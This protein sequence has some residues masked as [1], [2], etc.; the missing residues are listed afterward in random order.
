MPSLQ[1][2]FLTL[3]FTL[4][5]TGAWMTVMRKTIWKLTRL[6]WYKLIC[7]LP[8]PVCGHMGVCVTHSVFFHSRSILSPWFR[9]G[10]PVFS[11][12][13]VE[14][15][16]PTMLLASG[17][18]CASE[19]CWTW[20]ITDNLFRIETGDGVRRHPWQN[21]FSHYGLMEVPITVV[22]AVF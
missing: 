6:S 8:L 20:R 15:L 14:L 13:L 22:I 17:C 2:K 3:S 21:H 11:S 4:P 16:Q 9:S 12:K 10:S 5:C 7:H 18:F 1:L 19:L